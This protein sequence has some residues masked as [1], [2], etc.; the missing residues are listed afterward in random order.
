MTASAFESIK[1]AINASTPAPL[2]PILGQ[3]EEAR[4]A[5]WARLLA[6]QQLPK[7]QLS[8]RERLLT[9]LEAAAIAQV[10]AKR[11]Y[12]GLEAGAGRSGHLASASAS[13]R[14][15][16]AGGWKVGAGR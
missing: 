2:Q 12:P 10:P 9:P 14:P 11:I 16:S 6:P 13:P 15:H 4:A 5:A 8:E 7:P 3:L 1:Q